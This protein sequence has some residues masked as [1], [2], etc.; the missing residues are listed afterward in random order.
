MESN[1]KHNTQLYTDNDNRWYA[2]C[3][4]GD[5]ESPHFSIVQ[6]AVSSMRGHQNNPD[7]ETNS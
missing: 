2:K 1:T 7:L 4:E 3:D 6:N 5:Y